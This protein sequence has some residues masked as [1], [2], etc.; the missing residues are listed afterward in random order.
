MNVTSIVPVT[1]PIPHFE[2]QEVASTRAK[3]TSVASLDVENVVL[4]TDETVRVVIEA[5]V[6][7]VDHRVNERSGLLERVQT[8]RP[9]E[10][11]AVIQCRPRCIYHCY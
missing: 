1:N 6:V 9:V 4:T 2:G 8:L 3:M 5:R 10:V 7:G 11:L